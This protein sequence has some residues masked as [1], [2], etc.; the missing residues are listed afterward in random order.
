M[1][2]RYVHCFVVLL[3]YNEG[4]IMIVPE[5]WGHGVLNIQVWIANF[6]SSMNHI[7]FNMINLVLNVGYFRTLW[8]LLRKVLMACGELKPHYHSPRYLQVRLLLY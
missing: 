6:I 1:L 2:T 7:S 5:S 8:L 3:Y 4:D